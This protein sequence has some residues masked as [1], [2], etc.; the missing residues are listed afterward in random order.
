MIVLHQYPP[1]FKLPSLSPFCIK[2]EFFLKLAKL[3]YKVHV[4]RNPSRGPKG[5][6]PFIEDGKIIADSSYILDHLVK[7]YHLFHLEIQCPLQ[8]AQSLAFKTMIE[9]SLYFVLLY[10]RWIDPEGYIVIENEF[11]PLL[12]PLIG[13]PFL[14]YLKKNL[15]K[16][17]YEQGMGRHTKDEV[18]EIGAKHLMALSLLLGEKEHFFEDKIS[19]FDAT[20]YSFLATILKQ[21]IESPLKHEL[22]R[23]SN[24]CHYVQRLDKAM[25]FTC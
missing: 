17:A 8:K 18:Y 21:P 2:V 16:Q 13:R 23:R 4:E 15:T 9:E 6:M 22:M 25:E 19:V 3:P 10:S 1:S 11:V 20:A 14:T 12:P 24:L 7:N 5:K